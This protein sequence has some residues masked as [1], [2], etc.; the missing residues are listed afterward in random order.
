VRAKRSVSYPIPIESSIQLLDANF[1]LHLQAHFQHVAR[2]CAWNHLGIKGYRALE[3]GQ[4]AAD[5]GGLHLSARRRGAKQ[6]QKYLVIAGNQEIGEPHANK[7]FTPQCGRQLRTCT[8]D[9]T[10][11]TLHTARTVGG[12]VEQEFVERVAFLQVQEEACNLKLNH[13]SEAQEEQK[14]HY[15][16]HE[17]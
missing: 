11:R 2:N 8:A 6:P 9:G 17:R 16:G 4:A 12:V 7:S 1:A 15:H 3:R 10:R 14:R 5:Q 13:K